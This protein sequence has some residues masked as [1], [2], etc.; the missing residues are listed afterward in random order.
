MST[1][2]GLFV[3]AEM[4]VFIGILALGWMYAWKKGSLEWS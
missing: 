4:T 3:L 2:F 1:T